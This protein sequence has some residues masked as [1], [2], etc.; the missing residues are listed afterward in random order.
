MIKDAWHYPQ[1]LFDLLVDTVPR[2]CRSKWDVILFF[3]GAAVADGYLSDLA[4]QVQRNKESIS[5]FGI[6]RTVLQRVNDARGDR[7]LEARRNI[8][9]RVIDFEDFAS[10]WDNDRLAA[11]GLVDKV[12]KRVHKHDAFVRMQQEREQERR[13][14]QAEHAQKL[15][16]IQQRRQAMTAVRDELLALFRETDP[17]RRG[18]ACEGV[19]NRLFEAAGILVRK[20]FVLAEEGVGVVEQVDGVVEMDGR[21]Y[22]V[23]VK[24]WASPVAHEEISAHLW[25]TFQR[26]EADAIIISA[27]PFTAPAVHTCK[28]GLKDRLILLATLE[29]IVLLLEQEKD[30]V[31]LFRAKVNAAIADK[32]PF[33]EPLKAGVL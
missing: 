16:A 31:A 32:N 15:A 3:R 20:A 2:L 21:V 25:R 8:I 12:R 22:L 1:D 5:K 14:R 17:H 13:E 33:Y 23:E 19:L 10:C 24:W 11:E 29:E 26:A 6:V 30:L 9:Q 7:A 18:K 28:A 4:A 27:S